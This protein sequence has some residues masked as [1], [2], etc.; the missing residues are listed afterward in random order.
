MNNQAAGFEC[1]L[2]VKTHYFIGLKIERGLYVIGERE[3]FFFFR[4][5]DKGDGNYSFD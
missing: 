5:V 1:P 4:N 2:P 3:V